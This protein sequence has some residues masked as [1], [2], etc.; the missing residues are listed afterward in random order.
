MNYKKP[1]IRLLADRAD[2]IQG[3]FD[4]FGEFEPNADGLEVISVGKTTEQGIRLRIASQGIT[5]FFGATYCKLTKDAASW[6]EA[7][8]ILRILDRFLTILAERSDVSPGRRT[9]VLSLHL[10][11]K[12]GSF[13][14]I[15]RPLIVPGIKGLEPAPL[16]AMAIF[17]RWPRYRI[18][19][20]GSAQLANGLFVQMERD[21]DQD[22][23]YADMKQA[24]Y[25]DEVDLFALL[26]VEE[27]QP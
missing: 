3:L 19:L 25:K 15:L 23:S 4:A 18:T 22:L 11:L 24:I 13:K 10:Q 9:S 14:E 26:G 6:A 16:D 17:A 7:D 2:I 1:V 12:T 27:I 21:F 5:L 20:D 8:A